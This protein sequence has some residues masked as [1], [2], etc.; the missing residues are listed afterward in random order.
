ML[1]IP[2]IT[3]N[4]ISEGFNKTLD[5]VALFKPD[6]ALNF[7]YPDCVFFTLL[8]ELKNP[9]H[10]LDL[11]SYFGMLPI[12]T[13]KLHSLYGE[14]KKFNWTLIDNCSYVK[15]LANFTKGTGELSG[16]F[17]KQFHLNSWK[18]ANIMPFKQQMFEVHGE[19]CVPPTTPEEFFIFWEK[20]TTFYKID[21]PPYREMY[22][23]LKSIPDQRKFDLVLFD[24]AADGFE[25]NQVIFQNLVDNY[26]TDDAIIV[27]D[28][29]Y[30]KHPRG[31]ALFQWIIDTTGFLPVAFSTNKVALIK[32]QFKDK[33]MFTTVMDAGL[34]ANGSFTYAVPQEH[35]NFFF[36]TAY[37]WG[38]FLDLKAN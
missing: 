30:P 24:L 35:F 36:H 27:M 7:H 29:I 23:S 12:L 33:F 9:K 38:D 25:E 10:I 3:S 1:Q 5:H 15:E 4:F 32:K 34:R 14:N 37:K 19:Y 31:M 17:L 11:G 28:D 8:M 6:I 13:E 26:I 20:F 18:L 16:K 22:D 2:R 21:N